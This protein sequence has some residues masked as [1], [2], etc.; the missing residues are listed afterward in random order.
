ML[1]L[2]IFLSYRINFFEQF[3]I[4]STNSID[5]YSGLSSA[6]FS[7]LEFKFDYS[8]LIFASSAIVSSFS[9]FG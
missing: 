2:N 6:C 5:C 1:Y 4:S 3:Q 8:N 7:E 9:S